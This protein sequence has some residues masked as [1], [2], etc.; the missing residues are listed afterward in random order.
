MYTHTDV[1][2]LPENASRNYRLRFKRVVVRSTKQQALN[3][4]ID[5]QTDSVVWVRQ[6]PPE[7]IARSARRSLTSIDAL[8]NRFDREYDRQSFRLIAEHSRR[9]AMST[10]YRSD[11]FK[12]KWI[13][14]RRSAQRAMTWIDALTNRSDRGYDRQTFRPITEQSRRNAMSADYRSDDFK[15]KWIHVGETGTDRSID[16]TIGA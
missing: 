10:G 5:N 15:Q 2:E 16:R 11:D 6:T 3:A 1:D 9:N 14:V 4:S 12:Q 7:L 13:D 8:T